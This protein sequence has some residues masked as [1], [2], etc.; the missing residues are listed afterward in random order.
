MDCLDPGTY[1]IVVD[2]YEDDECDFVLAVYHNEPMD[3][4]APLASVCHMWDFNTSDEGFVHAP[5]GVQ[6][7][8]WE[9]GA[10]PGVIPETACDDVEVTNVLCTGLGGSYPS[11]AADAAWVGPVLLDDGCECLEV[12]HFY[13]TEEYYDGGMV[14]LTADGGVTWNL[15][16]PAVGYDYIGEW[17]NSCIGPFPCFT[18]EDATEFRT[19]SFD[20]TPWMGETVSIG[21][22]FG[23][24]GSTEELGWYI[25]WAAIG[26][27]GSAVENTTWGAIK[28]LYR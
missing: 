3:E 11:E 23:A 26:S 6:L 13:V 21:F 7:N 25:L 28:S 22:F 8:T 4:C 17:D 1:Y 18:G 2:D 20:L 16:T 5:C 27:S 14:G 19:D 15:L 24:D 10:A 9:W 12:C